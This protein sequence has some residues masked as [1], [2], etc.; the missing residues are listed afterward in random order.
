MDNKAKI[1]NSYW[2]QLAHTHIQKH[3]YGKVTHVHEHMYKAAW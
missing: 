2:Y 1:I 3:I